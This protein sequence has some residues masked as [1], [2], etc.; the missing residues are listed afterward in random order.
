MNSLD[1]ERQS[2]LARMQV[3]RE[4]Y[5]RMLLNQEEVHINPA[6]PEGR[7]AVYYNLGGDDLPRN[8]ALRWI[9]QHPILSAAALAV[10]V[11]L[12]SSRVGRRAAKNAAKAGTP[13]A[14]ELPRSTTHIDAI[15]RLLTAVANIAQFVPRRP[16]R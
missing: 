1:E 2:I 8:P 15:A 9:G 12:A 16:P 6:H 4:H 3:S 7:H 11:A 14:T 10:I 13:A 5:R